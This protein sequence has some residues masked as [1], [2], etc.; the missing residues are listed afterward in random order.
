MTSFEREER[1]SRGCLALAGLRDMLA[2]TAP[3]AMVSSERL[4]A[5]VELIEQDIRSGAGHADLHGYAND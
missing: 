4:S 5:L 2:H 3:G 1:L